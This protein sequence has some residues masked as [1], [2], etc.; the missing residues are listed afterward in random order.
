M[1]EYLHLTEIMVIIIYP[2]FNRGKFCLVSRLL[3]FSGKGDWLFRHS[4]DQEDE[5]PTANSVNLQFSWMTT[6][7]FLTDF[8]IIYSFTYT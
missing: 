7:Q 2:S 6:S 1:N 3:I 5:K 8:F 4:Y